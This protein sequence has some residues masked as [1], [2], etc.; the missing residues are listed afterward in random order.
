MT[1]T[2]TLAWHGM[3]CPSCWQDTSLDVQATVMVRLTV[4]GSDA[5]ESKFGDHEWDSDSRCICHNCD[6]TAEARCFE[7]GD[8]GESIFIDEEGCEW[9]IQVC[10]MA[11]DAD[12]DSWTLAESIDRLPEYYD[13]IFRR[14]R[15][16]SGEIDVLLEAEDLKEDEANRKA[17]EWERRFPF[18]GVTWV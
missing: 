18:A 9:E 8:E 2:H 12:T 4:D 7:F 3:I 10:A 15:L 5:D 14:T 11:Y 6:F 17:E 16:A 1:K 13:V